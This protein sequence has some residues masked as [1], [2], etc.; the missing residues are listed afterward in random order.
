MSS[1]SSIKPAPERVLIA[2]DEHL[3]A[4]GLAS[5]ITSL[6]F[7]VVG[8]VGDGRAAIELAKK[9]PPDLAV[10]DIRMPEL[11]G[12]AAAE[13]L[14]EELAVPSVIVSAFSDKRYIEHAQQIGVFGYLLKP[15]STENLR[16]TLAIAW[17]RATSHAV[18][19][20]RIDQL[21]NTLNNRKVVEQ[22]KW[23]LID[24]EGISEPEAHAR[25]QRDARNNRR[26]LVEVAQE[27]LSRYADDETKP[28]S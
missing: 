3:M 17:A 24:R 13:I 5:S 7:T 23:T 12:L 19:R 1:G 10:L 9:D 14:W 11:E 6:G 27:V 20:K 22:A 28:N 16:V 21:E 4:T 25:L 8:P 26:P 2:D 15:V 18:Q